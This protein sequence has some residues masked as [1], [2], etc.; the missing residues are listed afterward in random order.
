MPSRSSRSSR[1]DL[2]PSPNP[3]GSCQCPVW[4]VRFIYAVPSL[5][6]SANPTVLVPLGSAALRERTNCPESLSLRQIW[7]DASSFEPFS[8]VPHVRNRSAR[9]S[10]SKS[11]YA[12]E[13][14]DGNGQSNA[15]RSSGGEVLHPKQKGQRSARATKSPLGEARSK[16]GEDYSQVEQAGPV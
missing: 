11:M 4:S 6:M 12:L 14:G 2:S 3:R 13:W 1:H 10:P 15:V 16:G 7:Y 5:P 8:P 9:Q